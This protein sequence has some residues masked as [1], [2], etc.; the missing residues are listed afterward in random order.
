LTKERIHII[1]LGCPKNL[2]DSEIVIGGLAENHIEV[3]DDPQMATK[4]IINTCGFIDSA[5]E[6][7]I[8]TILEA[9]ELKHEGILRELIVMGCMSQRYSAEMQGEL[10]EVDHFFGANKM[11]EV[12]QYLTGKNY[13]AYDPALWRKIL[14]P[15][16]Y[17]FLKIAEGCDNVCSFCSIPMMRG[18]QVSRSIESL[19]KETALLAS[20]GVKELIVIAQDST[21]YG[22]DLEPKSSLTELLTELETVDGIEWIRLHYAHPSHVGPELIPFLAN[23]Q[24]VLPYLDIPIQHINSQLLKKMKRGLD[25]VG[26]KKV[27]ERMRQEIPNIAIRTSLIVGYPGEAK[28]M[29]QELLDFVKAFR[30]DRLGVFTYSEEEGT[31]AA[32]ES[33]SISQ[34]EKEKRMAAIM[35]AQQQISLENNQA[36]IGT[37][38]KVLIDSYD[39]E[40]NES[41]GRTYRDS[42]D[43]D[44]TVIIPGKLKPGQFYDV[45]I[46][47]ALEYDLFGEIPE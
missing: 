45:E 28:T 34:K 29:F 14:T 41:S 47:D 19:M 7:S 20:R 8:D 32:K 46:T 9:A 18:K 31:A 15:R 43:I 10:P 23:S 38:Q 5:R 6:E 42:P 39:A 37:S 25:G 26:I 44:N 3:V 40:N 22:W 30:F 2:V 35:N 17:A 13:L 16:H 12:L 27:L 33:D 24:K 36:L 11:K 4:I 1:T 21:S